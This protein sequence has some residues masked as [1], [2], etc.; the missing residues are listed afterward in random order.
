MILVALGLAAIGIYFLVFGDAPARLVGV[1]FIAIAAVFAFLMWVALTQDRAALP[2]PPT[3]R[4]AVH[5]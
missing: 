1:V 2:P 4:G 5:G 3:A